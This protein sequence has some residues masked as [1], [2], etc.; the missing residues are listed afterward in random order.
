M[1]ERGFLRRK[2]SFTLI[3]LLVVVAIIAILA[4]MLLPALTKARNTA[5][6]ISCT[7]NLKQLGLVTQ[8]YLSDQKEFLP[9]LWDT[10]ISCSWSERFAR[11]GYLK[12]RLQDSTAGK[13]V[14]KD[15]KW[16]YCPS[17]TPTGMIVDGS[18][19]RYIDIYGRNDYCQ[20]SFKLLKNPSTHNYYTDTITTQTGSTFL[21]QVYAYQRSGNY[22]KIHMRHN[23][24]AN[25][26]FGDG[27]VSPMN[28]MEIAKCDESPLRETYLVRD[29]TKHFTN[30]YFI[31][32]NR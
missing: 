6:D 19:T 1:K 10:V 32:P 4:G 28:R 25:F 16:M 22:W 15:G 30:L 27:H 11:N 20:T 9:P 12:W 5:R 31:I 7:N 23:K 24:K 8:M 2:K 3:E 21:N 14:L 17:Y 29:A 18:P 13:K 26:W